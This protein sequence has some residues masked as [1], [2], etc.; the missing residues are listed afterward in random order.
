MQQNLT[1]CKSTILQLKKKK[2]D[3]LKWEGRDDSEHVRRAGI[4]GRRRP[5]SLMAR[6]DSEG[7]FSEKHLLV[8]GDFILG[9]KT[10]SS[11]NGIWRWPSRGCRLEAP[12][13]VPCQLFLT[14]WQ[15][16]GCRYEEGSGGKVRVGLSGLPR[17]AREAHC[18]HK[19]RKPKGL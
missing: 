17:T 11:R 4:S 1:R 14:T 18:D 12:G 15:D 7:A 6:R 10:N 19:G 8:F 9:F 5:L 3:C 2:K 16:L 13:T